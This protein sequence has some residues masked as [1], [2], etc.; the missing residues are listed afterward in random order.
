MN[1]GFKSS[2]GEDPPSAEENSQEENKETREQL[3]KSVDFIL[4][5]VCV[6]KGNSKW[7]EAI[8]KSKIQECSVELRSH[9][10]L[11]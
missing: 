4:N 3:H 9:L 2:C 1:W 11:K 8:I 5:I 10:N 6:L 7:S